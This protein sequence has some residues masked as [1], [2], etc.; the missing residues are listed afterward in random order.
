MEYSRELIQE[1]IKK[2]NLVE[3]IGQYV[4]LKQHGKDYFGICPFHKETDASFSISPEK[5]IW[6]CFGCGAGSDIIDFVIKYHKVKFPQAVEILINYSNLDFKNIKTEANIIKFLKQ[7]NYKNNLLQV[8][9]NILPFNVMSKYIKK[10]IKEWLDEGI[11]Q[12]V[13]DK[14]EVRYDE[15]ANRAVFPIHDRYGNIIN[16]KGRTLY[17]N[18]KDLGISKYI[19]YYPLGC[20]D[21]LYGLPFKYDKIKELNEVIIVEGS[22]S[23]WKLEGWEVNN[24]LS[25]ETNRINEHQI[26]LLL[27][28]KCNITVALDK[29][30]HIKDIRKNFNKLSKFT[31]VYVMYDTEGL[32]N[33]KDSPCDKGKEIWDRLYSKKILLR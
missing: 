14:Y 31:N 5:N 7:F 6:Y 27:E 18:Y 8:E 26:R 23:V 16:V 2:I 19:Y 11:K 17:P 9:H 4:E 25:L 24:V 1:I 10:P 12:E 20:N 32:L 21:F 29:G 30:V 13:M 15:N 22:K 28:L 3:Y 33:D